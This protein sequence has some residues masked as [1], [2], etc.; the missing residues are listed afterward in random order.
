MTAEVNRR[1]FLVWGA[2][3][4]RIR[5]GWIVD[6]KAKHMKVP[7]ENLWRGVTPSSGPTAD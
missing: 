7:G 6:G 4:E 3:P 5:F 1:E 2:P